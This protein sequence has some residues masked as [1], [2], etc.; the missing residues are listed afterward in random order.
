L[1]C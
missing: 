1:R